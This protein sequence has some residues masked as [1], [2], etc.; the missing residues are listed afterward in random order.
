MSCIPTTPS[1]SSSILFAFWFETPRSTRCIPT[2]WRT[3]PVPRRS[4]GPFRAMWRMWGRAATMSSAPKTVSL[5]RKRPSSSG[6][7][8]GARACCPCVTITLTI[9]RVTS[10]LT[11]FALT[12]C[13]GWKTMR[14]RRGT[15]SAPKIRSPFRKSVRPCCATPILWKTRR[16]R[17][18]GRSRFRARMPSGKSLR[19]LLPKKRR[20][21][22]SI[23]LASKGL[24]PK[25]KRPTRRRAL[26][27]PG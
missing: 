5:A 27:A 1:P 25:R 2:C 23:G 22:P 14:L 7:M 16:A 20:K 15:T 26:R 10:V 17:R 9:P 21:L 12:R 6:V 19:S 18:H 4:S 13:G 3:L 8:R 24:S 11:R